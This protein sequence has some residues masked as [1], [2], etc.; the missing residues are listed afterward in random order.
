MFR[1][2]HRKS[3][4]SS[5]KPI[6]VPRDLETDT[7][8]VQASNIPSYI[9]P[10]K[11]IVQAAKSI[12]TPS[13]Y[14]I[15]EIKTWEHGQLRQKLLCLQEKYRAAL[16]L[17]EVVSDVAAAL[18]EAILDFN[19]Y[20]ID[21]GNNISGTLPLPTETTNTLLAQ[22]ATTVE[23]IS[24]LCKASQERIA[25]H[26]RT[27]TSTLSLKIEER[28]KENIQLEQE[29]ACLERK[30]RGVKYLHKEMSSVI[31]ILKEALLNFDNLHI[32]AEGYVSTPPAP[33]RVD[34]QIARNHGST[35]A[36]EASRD[37]IQAAKNR[38]A[39]DLSQMIRERT[40]QIIYLEQELEYLERRH[41][42]TEYLY[43]EIFLVLVTLQ[44]ALLQFQACEKHTGQR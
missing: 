26:Q 8:I 16:K 22:T 15:V 4:P 21:L 17:Y 24:T 5:S 29:L 20:N 14:Q 11:G 6:G 13:L 1:R 43:H 23:T 18:E 10:G 34:I 31:E 40:D 32:N 33:T 19:E 12:P 39:P 37:R 36:I 30:H 3:L 2:K 9:R 7:E 38:P 25:D 35:M 28:T 27:S 42:A 44:K 41:R